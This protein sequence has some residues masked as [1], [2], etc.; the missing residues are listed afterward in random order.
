[1]KQQC[2][3]CS[4]T[5]HNARACPLDGRTGCRICGRS[6][7][8]ECGRLECGNRVTLTA[9]SPRRGDGAVTPRFDNAD[10]GVR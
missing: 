2:T 7:H 8:H 10:G 4:S 9:N 5:E 1:M 6:S 3:L